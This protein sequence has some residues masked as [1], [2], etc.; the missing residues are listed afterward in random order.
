MSES[1]VEI[2]YCVPCGFLDRASDLQHLLLRTFG[3]RLDGVTLLTG[4]DGVF[5]IRVGEE[6][7]YDKFED[8]NYDPDEVVREVRA[9]L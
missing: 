3:E 6:V 7:V 2:E 9:R 1:T 4:A 5:R 8:G